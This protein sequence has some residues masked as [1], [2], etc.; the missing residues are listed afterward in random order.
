MIAGTRS[1]SISP[2]PQC[3]D[4]CCH[5]QLKQGDYYWILIDLSRATAF[6]CSNPLPFFRTNRCRSG[7]TGF[8]RCSLLCT[9]SVLAEDPVG[10]PPATSS[11]FLGHRRR[12]VLIPPYLRLHVESTVTLRVSRPCEAV[13][14]QDDV[15]DS[16]YDDVHPDTGRAYFSTTIT[17]SI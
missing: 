4:L 3:R 13:V 17:E 9:I 6:G 15:H 14:Y 10:L 8:W 5:F 7:T 1:L 12:T 2:W 11:A 16:T